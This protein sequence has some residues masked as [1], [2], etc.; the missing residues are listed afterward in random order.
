MAVSLDFD[1][2]PRNRRRVFRKRTPIRLAKTSGRDSPDARFPLGGVRGKI[3]TRVGSECE[4]AVGW[5]R[6]ENARMG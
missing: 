2:L 6:S 3:R 5:Q 1:D 4:F